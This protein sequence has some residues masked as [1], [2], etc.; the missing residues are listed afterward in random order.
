[1][2]AVRSIDATTSVRRTS[3]AAVL[4]QPGPLVVGVLNVTPDSFSDGGRCL[5]A[6][7]ALA[8]A[9][10]MIGA[11]AAIIDVG[12][13]STRPYQGMRPVNAA[14]ELARLAP[15]LRDLVALGTPVSIDTMK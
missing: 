4:A 10:T 7:T 12:A 13:E 14:D 8:Q 11:G 6:G 2:T 15:V 3:L 5:D 1:M 9:E